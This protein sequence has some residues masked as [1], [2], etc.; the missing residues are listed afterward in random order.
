MP[1]GGA[2]CAL[3]VLTK[4]VISEEQVECGAQTAGGHRRTLLVN[5]RPQFVR[6]ARNARQ[7]LLSAAGRRG[8]DTQRCGEREL[9]LAL[10]LT[11]IAN[12][13]YDLALFRTRDPR[14]LLRPDGRGL[15][16]TRGV[17]EGQPRER[18]A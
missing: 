6:L 14:Q 10:I 18:L 2:R 17:A 9:P 12:G 7:E 11:H 3:E 15:N 8:K 4:D 13:L 16:A 5:P 1:R